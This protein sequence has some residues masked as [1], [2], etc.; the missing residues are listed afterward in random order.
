MKWKVVERAVALF[1]KHD[2]PLMAWTIMV[3]ALLPAI[4]VV[5]L[6]AYNGPSLAP[7]ATKLIAQV[8]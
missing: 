8:F 4:L 1:L 3:L 5:A 7:A 6:L 2:Q